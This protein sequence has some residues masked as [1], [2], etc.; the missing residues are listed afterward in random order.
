MRSTRAATFADAIER[1]PPGPAHRTR[2]GRCRRRAKARPSKPGLPRCRPARV[3]QTFVL[4]EARMPAERKRSGCSRA[5]VRS[6]RKRCSRPDVMVSSARWRCSGVNPVCTG[7]IANSP[8]A[9]AEE[10]PSLVVSELFL[11]E[12]ADTPRWCCGGAA[13]LKNGHHDQPRGDVLPVVAG[14]PLRAK[15]GP[16]A[17]CS[18][19][20]PKPPASSFRRPMKSRP[21]SVCWSRKC[22]DSTDDRHRSGRTACDGRARYGARH[23]RFDDLHGGGTMA[24]DMRL[25]ELR[26][27]AGAT[28]HPQTAATM[29]SWP[30]TCRR[31]GSDGG[32]LEASPSR[33]TKRSPGRGRPH[34]RHPR[35]TAQRA[36]RRLERA[37]HENTP[38]AARRKHERRDR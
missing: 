37:R 26:T 22:G 32:R 16:T 23:R 25:G 38:N 35:R 31:R 3:L 14:V 2:V 29:R 15:R 27:P 20:S 8:L 11:T 1:F 13:R 17:T 6:I 9:C 7:R 5:R 24:H 28:I 18:S 36:P 4:G 21:V 30:A 33:S 10:D 19:R 34:R 12:T